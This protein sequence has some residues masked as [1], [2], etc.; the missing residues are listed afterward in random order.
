MRLSTRTM[1]QAE[2]KKY[3]MTLL[4]VAGAC[5]LIWY[6]FKSGRLRTENLLRLFDS[7]SL[8]YLTLSA[9]AFL[10]SQMLS[11]VRMIF[12]LKVIEFKMKFI[13][14][15]KLTM[16]GNF[17]NTVIPG[18]IGGDIVKAFYLNRNEGVFKGRSSGIVIIDRVVGLIALSLIGFISGIYIAKRYRSVLFPYQYELWCVITLSFVT[19]VSF[20]ALIFI[21]KHDPIRQGIRRIV[22]RAFPQGFFFNV[23]EGLALI[24]KKRRYIF[25]AFMLSIVVQGVSLAG[26]LI[27]VNLSGE[28][29]PDMVALAAVSSIVMLMGIIPLTPGNIGWTELLATFGWS[30]L[31]AKGGAEIFLSWRVITVLCSF[32]GGFYYLFPSSSAGD[33]RKQDKPGYGTSCESV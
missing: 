6:L 8:L 12:L 26:L 15:F 10:S 17:F 24:T 3:L 13:P 20:V 18:T 2:M 30:A 27:L 5:I 9:L 22:L 21:C 1:K 33:H 29:F 31:G 32:L 19:F 7:E 25:Y 4:K 16:I 11:A 14:I 23:I 28:N